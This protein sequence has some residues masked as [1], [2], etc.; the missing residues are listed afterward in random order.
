[1]AIVET[2]GDLEVTGCDQI[3]LLAS[4]FSSFQETDEQRQLEPSIQQPLFLVLEVR[5]QFN[6]SFKICRITRTYTYVWSGNHLSHT[7]K[8][9]KNTNVES[10]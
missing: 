5:G 2:I 1:M 7:Q 3:E 8:K 6:Y 10:Q 4:K 9:K